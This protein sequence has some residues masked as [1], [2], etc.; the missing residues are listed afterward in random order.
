VTPSAADSLAALAR[1]AAQRDAN[2]DA[3]LLFRQAI[4]RAPWRR[5]EWLEELAD[6]TVYSG[7]AADAVPLYH[8]VLALEG[9][10]AADQRRAQIGLALALA[11]S[12][13]LEASLRAYDALLLWDPDDLEAQLGR[14]RLLSWTNRNAESRR[15]YEQILRDHPDNVEAQRNLGRVQSWRGKHRAAERYLQN[16]LATHPSDAE[17]VL[18]LARTQQWMGRPDRAKAT[19]RTRLQVE[20]GDVNALGM[21]RSIERRERPG[22]HVDYRGSRQSDD[23]IIRVTSLAQNWHLNQ[24]LTTLGARYEFQAYNPQG[25][26]ESIFVHRPGA[27]GRHRFNNTLEWTG[28]A[29]IDRINVPS[30][31]TTYTRFTYNTWFTIWPSDLAR[32]DVGSNRAT[33]DNVPSLAQNIVTTYVTLAS[34][35]LPGE[36]WRA[37]ARVSWGDYSDGNA[38]LWGQVQGERR[39]RTNP[40]IWVGIRS[41]AFH[42]REVL[43]NGY[44]NPS[45]YFSADA[46]FR[47]F[48]PRWETLRYALSGSAG[49]EYASPGGNKFIWSAAVSLDYLLSGRFDVGGFL[50]HF[51]SA[52]ASSSGFARTTFGARLRVAW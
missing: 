40:R 13:Q 5:G 26:E 32:I 49:F 20:P 38:Q 50:G 46:T 25:D 19:L 36:L 31:D 48:E 27:Y 47:M 17:T 51:S 6:Q 16:V 35:V 41:T 23:L 9:R 44:F 21:L 4:A 45:D 11:W 18:L 15:A 3:M 37:T 10:S 7:L 29:Y 34:D 39:L 2:V 52:T 42:F 22:S 28:S 33:L 12:G 30:P 43:F 1:A 14:A 24:G 8:E